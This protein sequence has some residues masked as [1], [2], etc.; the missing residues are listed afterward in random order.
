MKYYD[1]EFFLWIDGKRTEKII[2]DSNTK[3]IA[4]PLLQRAL[5]SRQI[6]ENCTEQEFG[7]TREYLWKL[8]F[9]LHEIIRKEHLEE[10]IVK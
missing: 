5:S 1:Y 3:I 2:I 4:I 10:E 6:I 7:N 9:E 8:G